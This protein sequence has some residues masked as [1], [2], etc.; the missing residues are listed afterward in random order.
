VLKG[1]RVLLAPLRKD[2]L[3]VFFGWIN[4]RADVLS[5]AAYK[6]VHEA[7]HEAWAESVTKDADSVIFAIRRVDDDRL[8][9]YVQLVD[10]DWRNRSAEL[11]LRIGDK[12]ARNQHFGYEGTGLLL[13]HA[14]DDL[15]LTRVWAHVF[16]TN[17]PTLK[18]SQRLGFREEGRL[19][20]AAYV[21]GDYVDVVVIGVLRDEFRPPPG[22]SD[23][24]APE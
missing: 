22:P 6:P 15:N 20:K 16:A 12:D 10:I 13:T 19:R 9:G 17:A 21:G 18:G 11:R 23:G 2:D 7:A 4:D 3:E 24:S 14:F 8:V 1:E 5:A